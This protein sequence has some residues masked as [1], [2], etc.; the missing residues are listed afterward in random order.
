[1]VRPRGTGERT[2]GPAR[3][4]WAVP[5]AYAWVAGFALIHVLAIAA[6]GRYA[7]GIDPGKGDSGLLCVLPNAVV[8]AICLVA[9][10]VIH[11]TTSPPRPRAPAWTV[12]AG[13]WI[14]MPLLVLRGAATAVDEALRLTGIMRY[15]LFD[16][17]TN[18][19]SSW[20]VWSGRA[21]DVY[22]MIGAVVLAAALGPWMSRERRRATIS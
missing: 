6:N 21:I 16:Q 9:A 22:F 4:P 17:Q 7:A 12:F 18:A 3:P 2:A 14:G 10:G 5:A 11:R 1:M 8:I 19:T 15:G 20:A 13:A